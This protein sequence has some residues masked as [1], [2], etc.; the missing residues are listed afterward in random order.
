MEI[1]VF[2]EGSGTTETMIHEGKIDLACLTTYPKY[3]DINYILIEPEELVLLAGKN[4]SIAKRLPSGS[5]INIRE[6]KNE[7]FISIK[8]GHSVRTCLLYTSGLIKDPYIYKPDSIMLD[9]EDAV[10]ENQKD[11]ARYSLYHALQEIDYRGVEPV[12]YTH[13]L[14]QTDPCSG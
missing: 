3:E 9:L 11:A 4:T 2:E 8:Q 14:L 12:S 5:P 10:A 6:A 13:L 7:T 1:H